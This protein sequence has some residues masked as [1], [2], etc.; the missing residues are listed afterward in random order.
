[1]MRVIWVF[2]TALYRGV[3]A[4]KKQLENDSMLGFGEGS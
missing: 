2:I 1:M 3:L 4:V